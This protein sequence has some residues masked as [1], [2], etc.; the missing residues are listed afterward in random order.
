MKEIKIF[1]TSPIV[2]KKIEAIDLLNADLTLNQD[3]KDCNKI[4][5]FLHDY[6][7]SFYE[8]KKMNSQSY[9]KFA[10]MLKDYSMNH[11]NTECT[12]KYKD[13]VKNIVV[14]IYRNFLKDNVKKPILYKGKKKINDIL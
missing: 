3:I 14:A 10:L 7:T 6:L 1:Y 8:I 9:Y 13:L 12:F 4:N 11:V 5:S 2:H